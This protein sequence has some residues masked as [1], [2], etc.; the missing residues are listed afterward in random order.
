MTSHLP[1][2]GLDAFAAWLFDFGGVLT[3]MAEVYAAA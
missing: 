3:D 2:A 1:T